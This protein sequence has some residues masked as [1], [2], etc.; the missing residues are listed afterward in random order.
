[1]FD[2]KSMAHYPSDYN[3]REAYALRAIEK[4][5]AT[6]D[7]QML[8]LNWI[9]NCANTYDLSYRP[10]STEATAF[11]EGRRFVGLQIVKILKLNP[12]KLKENAN[13]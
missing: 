6:A 4:G 3:K 2:K 5:E 10:D 1:M 7:Q 8:A 9:V 12:G 11:A 13:D